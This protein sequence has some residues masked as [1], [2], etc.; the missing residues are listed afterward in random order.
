MSMETIIHQR[1]RFLH[2][3][4][5]HIWQAAASAGALAVVGSFIAEHSLNAVVSHIGQ[6][7]NA[8]PFDVTWD[9]VLGIF[10]LS[11]VYTS[12]K[13]LSDSREASALDGEIAR[14]QID[15]RPTPLPEELQST[16]TT[17]D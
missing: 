7:Y 12:L 2:K 13:A 1:D 4:K 9:S 3:E 17:Q 10:F 16:E 6:N 15:A 8:L 14:I 11:A 5:W